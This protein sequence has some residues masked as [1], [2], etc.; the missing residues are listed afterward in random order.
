[1]ERCRENHE[2]RPTSHTNQA[3]TCRRVIAEYS[4]SSLEVGAEYGAIR[5]RINQEPVADG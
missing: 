3:D 4:D 2:S 1:L 5:T